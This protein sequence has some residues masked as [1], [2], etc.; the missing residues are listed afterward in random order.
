MK[1]LQIS[2]SDCKGG[3]AKVALALHRG[4][5]DNGHQADLL[6]ASQSLLDEPGVTEINPKLI[7]TCGWFA[8]RR[9]A[10]AGTYAT[11]PDSGF[12]QN[13]GAEFL[14]SFDLLHL[15]DVPRLNFSQLP[16]LCE[17]LPVI[18]TLHT[19][20]GFT[21]NCL[22]DYGC[23]RFQD[24]CGDCP[25]HGVFPLN[26][27][28][29]DGSKANLQTKKEA[30]QQ[31]KRLYPVGVSEWI[32]G[33][34]RTSWM[35]HLD[36]ATVANG[37]DTDSF[38]PIEKSRAREQL[39]IPADAQAIL[40][41]IAS[42]PDDK[43]KGTD[44]ILEALHKL[45]RPDVWLIP[46]GIAEVPTALESAFAELPN[47][48][49]AVQHLDTDE[50]LRLHYS[51]ADLVWHPSR[52]DTSS[53]VSMEA[54]ACGTP[55][56]AASVGGVP[57]VVI[58]GQCG[59]LVPADDATALARETRALFDDPSRLRELSSTSRSLAEQRFP[60]SHMVDSYESVYQQILS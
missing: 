46:L 17:Q 11:A 2:G 18:W 12:P 47:P 13:L 4:L 42:N 16:W 38:Q 41:S 32:S 33:Q 50:D 29:V 54:C 49:L 55:V 24:S 51:A 20:G 36:I 10:K 7:G 21:G 14:A 23:D 59:I 48:R 5:R 39:G 1:V 45:D 27:F 35:R 6:V 15:H 25:Q 52:A 19:M 9:M 8:R 30:F 58:D 26:W 44:I 56:I 34:A 22:Y 60:A 43:R 57:E 3:A 53:L 37:I 28:P 31:S 40:F